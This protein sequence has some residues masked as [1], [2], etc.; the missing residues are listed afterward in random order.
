MAAWPVACGNKFLPRRFFTDI[1][2][3]A[4]IQII[5]WQNSQISMQAWLLGP[6]PA[7]IKKHALRIS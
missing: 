7:G 4:K 1:K 5:L 6:L 3:C 2:E